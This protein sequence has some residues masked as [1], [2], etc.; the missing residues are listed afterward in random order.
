MYT[1]RFSLSDIP[2]AQELWRTHSSDS[3]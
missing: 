2:D 3:R 1:L